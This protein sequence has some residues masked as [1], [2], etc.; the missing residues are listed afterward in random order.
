[1]KILGNSGE[2]IFGIFCNSGVD[3]ELNRGMSGARV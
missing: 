1:M 3:L 2:F